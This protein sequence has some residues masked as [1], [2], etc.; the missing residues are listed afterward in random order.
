M[1]PIIRRRGVPYLCIAL[2]IVLKLPDLEV[3]FYWDESWVYAPAISH[4]YDHGPSLMPDAI[5][6]EY[7][8]GHPLLF[9]ALCAAWMQLFGAS[10]VAMHSFALC[11][12]VA[13]ALAL[14]EIMLALFGWRVA[15]I[16]L[17]LLLLNHVFFVNSSFVLNDVALGLC[18]LL[19]VYCYA[20]RRYAAAGV[21]LTLLFF[22][23][24]SG[25][26]MAVVVAADI[27][28]AL[29]LR[30]ATWRDILARLVCVGVPLLLVG[31][32]FIVQ[33][34]V[35]GWY[36]YPGHTSIIDLSGEATLFNLQRGMYFMLHLNSNYFFYGLFAVLI[37]VVA[38]CRRRLHYLLVVAAMVLCY[39]CAM[40]FSHKDAVLYAVAALG[41]LAVAAMPWIAIPGCNGGQQRFLRGVVA[42]AASFL[43]FSCINFYEHRYLFPV[44]LFDGA[45]AGVLRPLTVFVETVCVR[46][47][48]GGACGGWGAHLPCAQ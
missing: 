37:V 15:C 45:G 10:H 18:M 27:A 1:Y 22:M 34:H 11:I 21:A 4:M 5:P 42:A 39:L 8:R 12:G 43:Y 46:R 23:K 30:K 28:V 25:L 41:A 3:A 38:V 9:H 40:V 48:Y 6:V 19:S 16:S 20:R 36:L 32:F 26:V 31:A 35:M 17:A 2:F 13:L 44:M 14:Y 7:S 47:F 29:V 33:K 24:E